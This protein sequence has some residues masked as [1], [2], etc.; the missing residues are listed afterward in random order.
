M[1]RSIE[2]A[3]KELKEPFLAAGNDIDSCAK[4]ASEGL[5]DEEFRL[6]RMAGDYRAVQ[7]ARQ[8]AIERLAS[9][10]DLSPDERVYHE[11]VAAVTSIEQ[12]D[13]IQAAWNA[14]NA[15]KGAPA[16]ETSSAAGTEGVKT[17]LEV[18]VADIHALY[19]SHPGCVELTPRLSVIKEVI[20]SGS[21]AI[22]RGVAWKRV[23]VV[24]ASRAKA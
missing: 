6:S 10:D 1:R 16:M 23:N 4:K 18:V 22:L 7:A 19:R 24:K 2:R 15:A 5:T 3:R 17:E 14:A 9:R 12:I 8:R 21:G 11:S 20:E 13:A